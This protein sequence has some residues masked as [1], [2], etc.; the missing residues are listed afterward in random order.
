MQI[1]ELHKT[2]LVKILWVNE[3]S[4]TVNMINV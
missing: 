4:D 2:Y 3:S 1:S